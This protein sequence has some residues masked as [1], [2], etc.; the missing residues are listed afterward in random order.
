MSRVSA[1]LPADPLAPFAP[2]TQQWFRQSF[3][4]ATPVQARGWAAIASGQHT[5]ML[6]PTG[7]GKTLAA[8][9]WCLDRLSRAPADPDAPTRVVYVSPIKAL[10]RSPLPSTMRKRIAGTSISTNFPAGGW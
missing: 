3:P 2:T 4:Q 10:V 6:A 7:S 9:L 5:L 1:D 8:F